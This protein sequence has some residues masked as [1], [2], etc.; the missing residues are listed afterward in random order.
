MSL[1]TEKLKTILMVI[2][3]IFIGILIIE[4]MLWV[5]N[6]PPHGE[7][8]FSGN[9]N[10]NK[11]GFS[12]RDNSITR[13]SSWEYDTVVKV[14]NAGFLNG[15]NVTNKTRPDLFIL[16]DSFV[17]GHGVSM[18]ENL[19]SQLQLEL[20]DDIVINLGVNAY[21]TIQ[22]VIRF[23][24][25]LEYFL[26][27][28]NDVFLVFYVGNDYYDNR[29]YT[30]SIK[31][32][33]KQLQTSSNGFVVPNGVEANILDGYL[34]FSQKGKEIYKGAYGG[35]NTPKNYKNAL[36]DWSKL[37]N[38]WAWLRTP[39]RSKCQIPIAI[40]GLFDTE[41]DF[42]SSKEWIATK[43]ALNDFILTAK[44]N[45]IIPHI[46]IMPS[47]YH[48]DPKLLIEAG[49]SL[50]EVDIKSSIDILEEF[51]KNNKLD[52]IN[53]LEYFQKL[54]HSDKGELYF[55]VDSHLT[56]YGNH[57]AAEII[58]REYKKRLDL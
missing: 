54:D 58:A 39:R 40:P 8:P 16:G 11:A 48:L 3:S 1:I 43:S 31:G 47:K 5:F 7:R 29:R 25:Y 6:I 44:N 20:I 2:V 10:D 33:G 21:S 36:F 15:K 30:D 12:L 57:L 51:A 34:I 49:C 19:P 24:Q 56:P 9:K 55:K 4:L 50:K 37:Y 14:N 35:F 26:H 32:S 52:S 28:P 46:V 42:K 45:N 23:K 27:K 13:L 53:L 18:E 22:E 38:S 17:Q 41:Y